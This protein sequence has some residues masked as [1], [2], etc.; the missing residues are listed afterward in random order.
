[1]NCILDTFS[2][3]EGTGRDRHPRENGRRNGSLDSQVL[4]EGPIGSNYRLP[5]SECL[6]FP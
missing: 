6:G 2:L 4:R 5:K 3:L 1:M